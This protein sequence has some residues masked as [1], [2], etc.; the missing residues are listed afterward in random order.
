MSMSASLTKVIY[1]TTHCLVSNY[2]N[3]LYCHSSA[4]HSV[5][6]SQIRTNLVNF[7]SKLFLAEIEPRN[8]VSSGHRANR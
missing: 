3:S 8:S 2:G 4:V 6:H 7:I 1:Q 5:K